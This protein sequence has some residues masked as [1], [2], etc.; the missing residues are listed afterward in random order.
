MDE[1][2]HI[3]TLIYACNGVSASGR[4]T[5]ETANELAKRGM[6]QK[7]CLAGVGAG[8]DYKIKDSKAAPRRVTLDGCK[9]C[10]AKRILENAG[11]ENNVSIVSVDAGIKLSGDRPTAGETEKFTDYVEKR[12][13]ENK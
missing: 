5:N 13:K 7:A 10:C 9:L 4:L 6:G 1:K 8:I 3:T 11:I 12:L 2:K